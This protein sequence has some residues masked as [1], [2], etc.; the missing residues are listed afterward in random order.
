MYG[1]QGLKSGEQSE[2]LLAGFVRRAGS[3]H[4]KQG[5]PLVVGTKYFTG[6]PRAPASHHLA[7]AA[8]RLLQQPGSPCSAGRQSGS[9][10]FCSHRGS[11]Q[12]GRQ[13]RVLQPPQL[14]T[15]CDIKSPLSSSS[16]VTRVSWCAVPWTNAL[17]GGGFR[18]GRGALLD[19]LRASLLRLQTDSIDLYQVC[20]SPQLPSQSAAVLEGSHGSPLAERSQLALGRGLTQIS[21]LMHVLRRHLPIVF[22]SHARTRGALLL[23]GTVINLCCE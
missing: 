15:E 18:L 8:L 2:Q 21:A 16:Y 19:A 23:L 6:D 12:P 1:Y 11:R 14:A 20:S 13:P 22:K 5:S 7:T 10:V 3:S 9:P 4:G 17:M